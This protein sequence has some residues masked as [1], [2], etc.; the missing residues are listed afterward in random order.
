[1]D[2]AE[3][4]GKTWKMRISALVQCRY[5]TLMKER[6][7]IAGAMNRKWVKMSRSL[8]NIICRMKN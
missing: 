2:V 4:T 1:M 7:H 8:S 6:R 3:D 5:I